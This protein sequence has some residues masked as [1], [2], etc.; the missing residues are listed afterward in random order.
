M[1]QLTDKE[2]S[3]LLEVL[4]QWDEYEEFY[5][6]K[7]DEFKPE[8]Y[9]QIDTGDFNRDGFLKTLREK[10]KA[11]ARANSKKVEVPTMQM[12]ECGGY[13]K[14]YPV[15]VNEDNRWNHIR[16]LTPDISGNLWEVLDFIY[17]GTDPFEDKFAFCISKAFS[18]DSKVAAFPTPSLSR[19]FNIPEDGV[20]ADTID[21]AVYAA[22]EL[23]EKHYYSY[24]S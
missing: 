19:R 10:L 16:Y 13:P 4:D 6:R 20:E 24:Y 9:K 14:P 23:F 21:E 22:A 8:Y 5:L 7:H 2:I 18:D 17:L 15:S 3:V 1:S 12:T 11:I